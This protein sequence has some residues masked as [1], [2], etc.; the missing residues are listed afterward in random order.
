MAQFILGEAFLS[1]SLHLANNK[2]PKENVPKPWKLISENA[3]DIEA[4]EKASQNPRILTVSD[5]SNFKSWEYMQAQ[6][7]SDLS[8]L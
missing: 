8:I 2:R 7:D 1:P 4:M 3:H 6:D 5:W